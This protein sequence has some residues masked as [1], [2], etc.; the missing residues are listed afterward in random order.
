LKEMGLVSPAIVP[1][2]PL[3]IDFKDRHRY[4]PASEFQPLLPYCPNP[5]YF[6]LCS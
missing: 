4:I 1:I 5:F 3:I 6:F 2:A